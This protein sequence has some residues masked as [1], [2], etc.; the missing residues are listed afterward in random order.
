MKRPM[1]FPLIL[2]SLGAGPIVA[3]PAHAAGT[4]TPP[5]LRSPPPA[6][7]GFAVELSTGGLSGGAL[8][9][10]WGSGRFAAGVALDFQ[11]SSLTGPDLGP[12]T[13]ELT[14]TRDRGGALAAMGYGT[15]TG[16]P[17]GPVRRG[18]CPV[19]LPVDRDEDQYEP[20]ASRCLRERRECS[21]GAGH[22]LLGHPLDGRSDT[23]HSSR[24]A[25]SPGRSWHSQTPRPSTRR[26]SSST[27]SRSRSSGGSQCWR[28]SD[29]RLGRCDSP[30][31]TTRT[32]RRRLAPRRWDPARR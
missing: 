6:A 26:P 21:A 20:H 14:E 13:S 7:K 29:E 32:T 9:L 8:G 30:A 10:G 5:S 3:A 24:S 11:H 23:R 28:C 2:F 27:S 31:P 4:D 12:S 19:R 22:P 16:R 17:C 1:R 15:D 18:G 25:A